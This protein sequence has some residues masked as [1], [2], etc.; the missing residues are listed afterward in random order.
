MAVWSR[1]KR[2]AL[3]LDAV[4][5]ESY[6]AHDLQ[7]WEFDVLAAL[8]RA[9]EPYRLSPGQLLRET[10]V[11]SGTMT[12]RVDRLMTRGFVTREADPDD[13]RG[14]LVRLTD[15]GRAVVDAAVTDLLAAETSLLD[16]VPASDRDALAAQLRGLL[17][18]LTSG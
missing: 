12:N 8:R 13:G 6:A 15:S 16:G 10:H 4:R 2:L 9:G 3:H 11:T 5:Q 1:I 7:I 14:V 18:S 17:S